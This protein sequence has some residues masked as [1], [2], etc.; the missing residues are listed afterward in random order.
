MTEPAKAR[1]NVA[2]CPE[3]AQKTALRIMI[4]CQLT[5]SRRIGVPK[6]ACRHFHE[7]GSRFAGG[8]AARVIAKACDRLETAHGRSPF[9]PRMRES[10]RIR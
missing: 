3:N 7:D 4:C 1:M 6:S 9:E 8:C 2:T 5:A 10:M